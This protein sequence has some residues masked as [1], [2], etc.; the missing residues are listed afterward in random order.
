MQTSTGGIKMLALHWMVITGSTLLYDQT[1][2]DG[3]NPNNLY[4]DRYTSNALISGSASLLP[5]P[6]IP[7]NI[8][9]ENIQICWFQNP[10]ENDG[11]LWPNKIRKYN[12]SGQQKPIQ[13]ELLLPVNTAVKVLVLMERIN[14][15]L[16]IVILIRLPMTLPVSRMLLYTIRMIRQKWVITLM[17]SMHLWFRL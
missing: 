6:I 9:G 3:I 16:V 8:G 5:G 1:K 17:K 15:L 10:K 7:V 12:I 2:W 4:S 14:M 11:L 13:K